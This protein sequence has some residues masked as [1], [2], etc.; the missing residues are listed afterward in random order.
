MASPNVAELLYQVRR[1]RESRERDVERLC[2]Q[3]AQQE[4]ALTREWEAEVDQ[5]AAQRVA[6]A[7]AAAAP[8]PPS[9]ENA[10]LV[11]AQLNELRLESERRELTISAL[12][13]A[14]RPMT[15]RIKAA[16][17]ELRN[18]ERAGMAIAES[19]RQEEADDADAASRL[20]ARREAARV[21]IAAVSDFEAGKVLSI[22]DSNSQAA[23]A[24]VQ[25]QFEA[26][27]AQAEAG[28]EADLLQYEDR[29]R[30]LAH[31]AAVALEQFAREI[32]NA[33]VVPE[34]RR[35]EASTASCEEGLPI[36]ESA[37]A[38]LDR[39]L[40][41]ARRRGGTHS[42]ASGSDID[43]IIALFP[44]LADVLERFQSGLQSST[45]DGTS[46]GISFPS[47]FAEFVER[48]D[49]ASI[50]ADVSSARKELVDLLRRAFSRISDSD[51]VAPSHLLDVTWALLR[52]L[53]ASGDAEL[54]GFKLPLS[55]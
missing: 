51:A 16:A 35:M 29:E 9:R 33:A 5:L 15:E 50:G 10:E 27:A 6:A 52:A 7:K 49:A 37:H 41:L 3:A 47:F 28:V 45:G 54:G 42:D 8:P 4:E 25:Q 30:Q 46:G 22:W 13:A 26:G 34:L 48:S 36:A 11:L 43:S 12:E 18:I 38:H 31:R 2:A 24:A 1:H 19:L 40:Q 14:L 55:R 44:M 39:L 23:V 20:R 53:A 17:A 32:I 21:R